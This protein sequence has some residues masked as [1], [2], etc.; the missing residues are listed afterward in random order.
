MNCT[1]QNSAI[2]IEFPYDPD[3]MSK[4]SSLIGRVYR[5]E[6]WFTPVNINNLN[7]LKE[8]GFTLDQPLQKFISDTLQKE[9]DVIKNEI[10]G[11]L[12]IPRDFQKEAV[13]FTEIQNGNILNADDQGLG[14]TI[15]ALCWI[16]LHR[17][18]SPV[19]IIS[20]ASLKINW[21]NESEKW[22][23]NPDIEVLKGTKPYETTKDIL[24]LNY[25]IAHKWI[26]EIKRRNPKILVLDEC[27]AIKEPK[28]R[29]TK[30]IQK[31]KDVP[32]KILLSGTPIL[33]RRK[34]IFNAIQLI[35]PG[36]FPK[37]WNLTT[38]TNEEL[39]QKLK[40]IMIR[41]L[42][43]DV[44]KEL[45]DKTYSFVPM[46]LDNIRE[47]K[48]AEKDFIEWV[49]EVKGNEKAEKIRT[50][51]A[52]ARVEGLTQLATKGK[53]KQVTEWISNFLESG[54]KLVVFCTHTFT[55]DTLM[56]EFPSAV[57]MDGSVP[58]NKRQGIVDQFQN[59]EKTNLFIGMIDVQGNPAGVGWTLTASWSVAVIELQWSPEI[60]KQAF[61][62][63]HRLTQ[64][65]AVMI[66]Y[67]L[68]NNT[69]E[70]RRAK[71]LDKKLKEINAIMNGQNVPVES[72]LEEF[73][74]SYK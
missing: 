5:D 39:H 18:L 3:L 29:R 68:A 37:M 45:P 54:Q 49:R 24:I 57:K 6:I 53:L 22:L 63:V 60:M 33:N 35:R 26:T 48:K 12:G 74:N 70:E 30:A 50:I 20:P 4:V 73:M 38:L 66:Y 69:I 72:L 1:L 71:I 31:L 36:M 17:D 32:H 34:E 51:E 42:K 2:R 67:L 52:M 65:N 62:R 13:A 43:Q 28:S 7:S 44:L 10:P 40:S 21:K 25:D 47:Y 15:E 64:K 9:Q 46:E 23:S 56:N 59:D 27:T 41:R 8:W 61:D 58:Q 14:K 11:L 19:V 16:Q 55:I